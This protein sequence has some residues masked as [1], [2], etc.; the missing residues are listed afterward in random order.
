[1]SHRDMLGA[2]HSMARERS[3]FLISELQVPLGRKVEI[4]KLRRILEPHLDALALRGEEKG[5]DLLISRLP[6]AQ[7]FIPS[8]KE[9]MADEGFLMHPSI[10]KHLQELI[11][12]YITR[13]TGKSW[14]D[15]V[16]LDR[17]RA[18]IRAQKK[19]YWE[20]GGARAI[21][22]RAGYRVLAY[23]A[24]QAPV[25]LIQ[26][27]HILHEMAA[28]GLIKDRMRVLD[29]GSG[30]GTTSL[31]TIHAWSRLSPGEVSIF[32]LEKETENL[33]AS[34]FL[35]PA[36]A[37]GDPSVR[38]PE[39]VQADLMS[40]EQGALPRELDL[41]VFG[42][43][44]NELRTLPAGEKAAL[45]EKI[46]GTLA[47]DGTVVILEPADLENSLALRKVTMELVRKGMT[48]YA[49]CTSLWGTACRPD[50]CWTFREGQP[51]T[52]PRLMKRLAASDDGYRYLNT[53]IK[54]SYAVL[55]KDHLTRERYR[56]PRNAKALRLSRLQ[57]HKNKRVNVVVA[58]MSGDLGGGHGDHVFKVCDGTPQ[59]PVFAVVP[60]HHAGRS[61]ALLDGGYGEVLSL[62]NILVRSNP[63]HDAFNLLVDRSTRV[64]AIGGVKDISKSSR[65]RGPA[66]G[67][68]RRS[69][70]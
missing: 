46:S 21:S 18:A 31:A 16:V 50:R 1:M 32:A 49:P 27:E 8:R 35:V 39:P 69:D 54:F 45:V 2:L 48:L 56:I 37:T 40:V 26:F 4:R 61:R 41:I 12:S 38:I 29:V 9:R 53:D 51:I 23:L 42:N 24:Y 65:G 5:D 60:N 47:G 28:D 33:E 25:S 68:G 36:F 17:I 14:D 67:G 57:G 10:P 58:K 3:S 11:E 7:P 55:R 43:V 20:Q 66:G 22:Y 62:E 6:P 13:K 34:R 15:P 52:P 30:P 64:E 19:E 44:L 59:K 70:R 63:S